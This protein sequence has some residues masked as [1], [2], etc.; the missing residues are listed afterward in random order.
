[1][2]LGRAFFERF[3]LD[4]A[5]ELL[6]KVIVRKIGKKLIRARIVETEA[7]CG[8]E[9]QACHARIGRTK[10]NEVMYGPAGHAYIY[11]CYGIHELLN[12]VTQEKGCP[13]AV[14]IR[15][16]EPLTRSNLKS[17][18]PGNLTRYLQITRA[19]NSEDLTKSKVFWIE[20]DG[21]IVEKSQIKSA[22][23]IGV[24]YAGKWAKKKW[25]FLNG[26]KT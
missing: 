4:V 26:A 21:F 18:G 9:D 12:I 14:L 15:K 19:L 17:Y 22:E 8:E 23:R 5:R 24:S 6:G 3:T 1:M 2:K 10:R 11:L 25:R 13:E 16:V 20:D 7:Y